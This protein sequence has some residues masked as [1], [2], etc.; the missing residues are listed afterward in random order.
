MVYFCYIDESGTPQIPG[1]T[2]HYVLCGVSI[3]VKY[4]KRCDKQIAGIKAKYGLANAE[5][6]TGW[7]KRTY[8]EQTKIQ[9]FD[10]LSYADRRSAVM[11]ARTAE[12]YRVKKQHN[13]K[14][15]KQ[16]KKNFENTDPY[17]HL[18]YSERMDFLREVADAIGSWSY[19]RIFA[20]AIDKVHFDPTKAPHAADE[21]AFEQIV[22]RFEYFMSNVGRK[23]EENYGL[24]IHDNNVTESSKLTTLMKTFHKKGTLWTKIRHIIET[25][26]FVDSSL[27]GMIQLADL[28]ALALRRYFEN[29]ET[30]LLD[31]I[32][33]RFDARHGKIVGVRHFTKADCPCF[34]CAPAI[35][36]AS[37][38]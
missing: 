6:H 22:S 27:T 17:I 35:P 23:D 34:L 2:S 20:E 16:L 32:K 18:T 4:W 25:P 3:P 10:K 37:A 28:C 1:N 8:L 12:V 9:D 24:L 14:A 19:A 33:P 31:R 38:E 26:L 29:G 5:I 30:D 13:P 15:L 36:A 7:I 11:S 21:Q